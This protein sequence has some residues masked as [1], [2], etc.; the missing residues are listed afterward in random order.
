MSDKEFKKNMKKHDFE[1]GEIKD[2]RK[3]NKILK[4]RRR[5]R[6]RSNS[7]LS[8]YD[9]SK[10]KHHSHKHKNRKQSSKKNRSRSRSRDKK[11]KKEYTRKFS[12]SRSHSRRSSNSFRRTHSKKKSK[13]SNEI[14]QNKFINIPDSSILKTFDDKNKE[15][16]EFKQFS[17][18]DFDGKNEL[19]NRREERHKR[20]EELKKKT[21]QNEKIVNEESEIN[22]VHLS[23]ENQVKLLNFIEKEREKNFQEGN[24][25]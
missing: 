2:I 12:R 25:N 1:D 19:V 10:G 4:Q 20:I 21:E 7:S 11:R 18:E 8:D 15:K 6:S 3:S 13:E 23:K 5:S 14:H 9:I 24:I 22:T 17:L 16:F